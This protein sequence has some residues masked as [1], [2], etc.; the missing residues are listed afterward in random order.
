[1]AL[2]FGMRAS[3][4]TGLQV[5]DLTCGFAKPAYDSCRNRHCPKCQALEQARWVEARMDRILPVPY[6]HLV[7]TLPS[8]LHSLAYSNPGEIFALLF[9]SAA[10]ALLNLA[11]DPKWFGAAAKLG[12]TAVLH[13]WTRDLRFH[14]HIHCILTGGGLSHNQSQWIKATHD[15]S[16]SRP[17]RR[18]P[19]SR[20]IHGRLASAS[21]Q[22]QA[23]RRCLGPRGSPPTPPPVQDQ[24]GRLRQALLR[25]SR[26]SLPL[27]R[28]LHPSRGHQQREA[29]QRRRL[30]RGLSDAQRRDRHCIAIGI[31]RQLPPAH[32]PQSLRQ[33]PPL[34]RDGLGQRRDQA[35]KRPRP[36]PGIHHQRCRLTRSTRQ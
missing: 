36:S 30:G 12:I 8:E 16:L 31:H 4:I 5:R 17:R 14:P 21:R 18:Q 28:P 35:G 27:S 9:R 2:D 26:A 1:M 22:G 15:F 33:D 34:R 11:A 19:V 20:Q 25:R 7:F 29:G 13:T 32:S 3:E 24:L 10:D 6:F 23:A